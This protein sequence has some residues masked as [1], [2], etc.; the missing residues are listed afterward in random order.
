MS[1][2]CRARILW[3]GLG[4]K[5]RVYKTCAVCPELDLRAGM[6]NVEARLKGPCALREASLAS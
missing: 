1:A 6:D 5:T 4:G 2:I 3:G